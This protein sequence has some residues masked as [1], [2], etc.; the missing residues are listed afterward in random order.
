MHGLGQAAPHTDPGKGLYSSTS[1]SASRIFPWRSRLMRS[2]V[3]IPFGQAYSHGAAK[4][5]L[6]HN[7]KAAR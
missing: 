1:S 6:F 3:G 2:W 4:T 5:A 7:G